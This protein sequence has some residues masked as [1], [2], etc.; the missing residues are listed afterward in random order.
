MQKCR[1]V[2]ADEPVMVRVRK[3]GS[4]CDD[5][6]S[7]D[8]NIS[9]KGGFSMTSVVNRLRNNRDLML[10]LFLASAWFFLQAESVTDREGSTNSGV[11]VVVLAM[12]D[13]AAPGLQ[14]LPTPNSTKKHNRAESMETPSH[15]LKQASILLHRAANAIEKDDVLT[16][17]LIRQVIAILKHHVIPSLLDR[18]STLVPITWLSGLPE[19]G[20]DHEESMSHAGQSLF[21]QESSVSK[22]RGT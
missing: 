5:I 14:G 13:D 15:S 22:E 17:Q 7:N 16:V 20:I 8:L 1:F 4:A 6:Q 18:H 12:Q 2:L 11:S 19:Q 3:H 9:P 10:A 21:Q